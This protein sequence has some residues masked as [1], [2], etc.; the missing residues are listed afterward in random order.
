MSDP[1]EP[2]RISHVLRA[3]RAL[4]YRAHTDP[5]H[6]ARWMGPEGAKVIKLALDARVGGE[7]HYGYADPEGATTWGKQLYREVVPD[8]KLVFLQSF[9][10]EHGAICR[11]PMAA[12]WPLRMLATTTFEDAGPGE[13]K[14]T[15]TWQPY[16]ADDADLA[17]FEG[18]RDG[19]TQGFG[20][21]FASLD[22]YLAE[23]QRE[24]A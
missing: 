10:D 9:S 18:A 23:A 5:A 13:T 20:G 7:C 19:M 4:V 15:V 3:P 22:R 24:L 11:H 6:L 8:E 2:F 1:V 16:E 14:V 12:T 21:M 17:T